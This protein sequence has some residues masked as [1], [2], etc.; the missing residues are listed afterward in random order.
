MGITNWIWQT[1]T[2]CDALI[3]REIHRLWRRLP[4]LNAAMV[5]VAKYTPVFMLA[6]LVVAAT[7]ILQTTQHYVV[8]FASVSSSIVAAVAIRLIHE[9]I[10]RMT[11]R[12]RPFDTEP[13]EP[14]LAHEQGES[15][16]SNHAGGALALACGAIHLPF[17]REILLVMA[18]CLCF[19][20]IYCGLHHFSDVVVGA[21]GGTTVGLL[22]AGIQ[23]GIHLS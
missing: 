14:L 19:S 22:C 7:G 8:T 11:A 6:V 15:F 9:P 17:F 21:I 20:R 18:L 4:W 2:Y 3:T 1:C 16:P 5:V 23:A 13:F 12:P 10:S